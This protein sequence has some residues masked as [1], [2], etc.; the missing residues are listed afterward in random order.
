M[1]NLVIIL[2][3][4]LSCSQAVNAQTVKCGMMIGSFAT[5]NFKSSEKPFDLGFNLMPNTA[6]ITKRTFHNLFYGFGN[7][8]IALN[9]GYFLPKNFDVYFVNVKSLSANSYYSAIGGEKMLKLGDQMCFLL[10]EV[11]IDYHGHT[12]ATVGVLM[13]FQT[14]IWKHK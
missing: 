10:C 8:S 3:V 4:A 11:G 14:K 7:N 12:T 5:T 13:T 9:Q 2:V 6:F 1:K